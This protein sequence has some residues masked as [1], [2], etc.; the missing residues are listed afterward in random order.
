MMY[1][2][3]IVAGDWV[4]FG[5]SVSPKNRMSDMQT[6]CPLPMELR[7]SFSGSKDL[8]GAL[9]ARFKDY[10]VIGEWFHLNSETEQ[11]IFA[12]QDGS[13]HYFLFEP[14]PPPP[15]RTS[16]Y[17]VGLKQYARSTQQICQTAF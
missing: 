15:P 12:M 8:E 6:S 14:E 5:R 1:V 4:K 3:A 2:Y 9:H 11:A 13:L 10:R 7:A 16:V 17:D